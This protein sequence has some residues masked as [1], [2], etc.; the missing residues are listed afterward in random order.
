MTSQMAASGYRFRVD[1]EPLER[2]VAPIR[3]QLP[4]L[5][6]AEATILGNRE[7][8]GRLAARA[9]LPAMNDAVVSNRAAL[10]SGPRSPRCWST[11]MDGG[12]LRWQPD[13]WRLR[14]LTCRHGFIMAGCKYTATAAGPA[15]S[16]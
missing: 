8:F 16:R 13:W 15:G 6:P 14:R 2:D 3:E 7:L 12:E 4:I 10:C 5:P 9:M 1:G 11:L